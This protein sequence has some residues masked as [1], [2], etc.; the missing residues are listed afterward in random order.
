[1]HCFSIDDEN[2]IGEAICA[3]IAGIDPA[4][5][6]QAQR[7]LQTEIL[8]EKTR[9]IEKVRRGLRKGPALIDRARE[10]WLRDQPNVVALPKP[11]TEYRTASIEAVLDISDAK[12]ARPAE[13]TGRAAEM[14]EQLKAEMAVPVATVTQLDTPRTRFRRALDLEARIAVGEQLDTADA[15]WLG[16]YQ[17]SPEYAG[18]KMVHE[19]L[20]AMSR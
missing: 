3:E 5:F 15:L 9:E 1:M 2:Y 16:G 20:G 8:A 4:A 18:Q 11:E 19:D 13:L 12:E 7:E 6:V 14:H 10:V 17:Q